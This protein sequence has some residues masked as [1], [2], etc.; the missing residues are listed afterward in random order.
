[1][2]VQVFSAHFFDEGDTMAATK[3][4]SRYGTY[5]TTII[6]DYSEYPDIRSGTCDNCGSTQFKSRVKDFVFIRECKDCG[7]KKSI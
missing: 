7:M 1:M 6:Y 2:A 4:T 3:D 5:D